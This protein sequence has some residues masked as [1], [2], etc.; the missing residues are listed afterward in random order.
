VMA[1]N[2][3]TM[4]RGLVRNNNALGAGGLGVSGTLHL[5]GT[6]VISN[7]ALSGGGGGLG[8]QN[9]ATVSTTVFITN[10]AFTQNKAQSGDGG[11]LLALGPV[12]ITLSG[13]SIQTRTTFSSNTAS[14][15]GG[16]LHAAD[17][18]VQLGGYVTFNA[19]QALAGQG[20]A[21]LAA[22]VA[23]LP[24][25]SGEAAF[26]GNSAGSHGGAIRSLGR[27][28]LVNNDPRFTG[29]TA[30]GGTTADGGAIYAGGNVFLSLGFSR[31]NAARDGGAV[32]AL[33]T[34]FF[35]VHDT[36]GSNV[37]ARDGGC[38]WSAQTVTFNSADAIGCRAGRNGGAAFSQLAVRLS[39]NGV[40][41]F[42]GNQAAG[43]GGVAYA[44]LV[45][46]FDSPAIITNSA[47]LDGGVAFST[48]ALHIRGSSLVSNSAR[49]HGGALAV[50]GTAFVSNTLFATN[51]L[52]GTGGAGGAVWVTGTAIISSGTFLTNSAPGSP[53]GALGTNGAITLLGGAFQGNSAGGSGGGVTGYGAVIASGTAFTGNTA[54]PDAW[55]AG[56]S[57]LTVTLS[58]VSM[59]ANGQ[60]NEGGGG[61]YAQWVHISG[62]SFTANSA[63]L[64][65]GAVLAE[66]V[67]V[68]SSTFA[69]NKVLA[70][71]A[72]GGAISTRRAE[73][74]GTT[75][76]ANVAQCGTCLGGALYAN[77]TVSVRGTTFVANQA[78]GGGAVFLLGDDGTP[79]LFEASLFDSNSVNCCG[80]G[81]AL[82]AVESYPDIVGS[83]FINNQVA[84]CDGG[85]AVF[86]VGRAAI[87][88]STFISNSAIL[89][90]GG[91]VH[92]HQG[93]HSGSTIAGSA[94]SG[95]TATAGAACLTGRGGAVRMDDGSISGSTFAGNQAG[96][97]GALL[98]NG[99]STVEQSDFSA[100]RAECVEAITQ[101]NRGQ[102]GAILAR[103]TLT[104]RRS[105]FTANSAGS[106]GGGAIAHV[107]AGAFN[108][109][110]E[111][112]LFAG[113]VATNSVFGA[114]GA[115]VVISGTQ[116]A[117]VFFNTIVAPA[118][119]PVSAVAVHT[120]TLSAINNILSGHSLGIERLGG[121]AFEDFNLFF[122][123]GAN[124]SPGVTSGGS[125]LAGDP[126][127][128]APG[129]GDYHLL[130][131]SPAI[132]A[133]TAAGGI[134][135]DF[136]GEAR[137]QDG[138]FDIGFDEGGVLLRLYLPLV[139]R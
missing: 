73:I 29:N 77:D 115:A 55:G 123:N 5:S 69:S 71:S 83:T 2:G 26:S 107:P 118:P 51:R 40:G 137:P 9:G 66:R 18:L 15:N 104:V 47:G 108:L 46:I 61:V 94:F 98:L 130:K 68:T 93:F 22:S 134:T 139:V 31:N 59:H 23:A 72:Q 49:L 8:Y 90:D 25:V 56:I 126:R 48:G 97:G 136:D 42:R 36:D 1:L 91:A 17:G 121:S 119:N 3:L 27:V 135:V 14:V 62:S 99:S 127:F 11:G 82:R 133:G 81:G 57:A 60:T 30:G 7:A 19:N 53:G 109:R 21:M 70:A 16:G 80:S 20:G 116:L 101:S 95:N 13:T 39:G 114:Q 34:V 132:D 64:F 79:S 63:N 129:S 76:S 128:V 10:A 100:N 120:G 88:D 87:S 33:G 131:S 106:A 12:T 50:S 138:G 38:A 28:S 112:S 74:S 89:A 44:P 92:I 58:G 124:L 35:N 4:T 103:H 43:S 125:S 37:A 117:Q 45:E 67:F 111:N 85:G 65:G 6:T 24:F 52:T 78:G 86:V 110:V 102:A 84:C 96:F 32:Y 41:D 105:R 122:A 113:N 54:G 75:F